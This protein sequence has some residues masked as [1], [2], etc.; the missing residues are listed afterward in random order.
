MMSTQMKIQEKYASAAK[1]HLVQELTNH[2]A[3]TDNAK[4]RA[5]K[6]NLGYNV[7]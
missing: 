5:Y 2:F 1:N 4:V 6:E 7:S 3:L